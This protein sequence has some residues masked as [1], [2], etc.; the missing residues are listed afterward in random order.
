MQ[1]IYARRISVLISAFFILS[2]AVSSTSL[3]AADK[4]DEYYELMK[5]FV[6]TF[7]Q[8][9]RN[10]V[11]KVDRKE[12]MEAAIRGMVSKLDQYSNY[13]SP[14][15]LSQFTQE[16]EQEFGGI[17]I[18]VQ[19]DRATRR[20]LVMTPL[21]GTP[22]YNAG[23]RAG[24]LIMD[25]EGKSTE[26]ITLRQAVRLLKGK[27]GD[28]VNI[29]IKHDDS[30]AIEKIEIVRAV[31]KVATVLGDS[32]NAD[33]SWNFMVDP[34]NKIGFIRLTHF[35]R[36]SNAELRAAIDQLR[37]QDMKGLIIDLRFNPGGL[38]SQAVSIADMFIESGKIVSTEGNNSPVR[39]FSAHKAGTYTDFP[40]AILVNRYSASASEIVGACLQDHK[41]AVI[42]G[43]RSWGKG[44]VQNV[45]ELG[46]GN[47]ALKL[48]TASYHRPS[49]KNIH[50]FPGA[51]ESDEWGV[52]PDE[53]YQVRFSGDEM[54]KYLDYRRKRDVLKDEG[55]PESDYEDRQFAKAREYLLEKL[56]KKDAAA[57]KGKKTES[58]KPDKKKDKKKENSKD[59]KA[60]KKAKGAAKL[61]SIILIPRS[62]T[63]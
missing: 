18:Q 13:I 3:R 44:S 16:V 50:K 35:S 32:Y 52:R 58:P 60:E 9:E 59:K 36:R 19:I 20:L 42:V 55:P 62:Q 47:S 49:G 40:I 37:K 48:T 38:L 25:I 6:D 53:G 5:T 33:D 2:L 12:L 56:A 34:E 22:A 31:I 11:K 29:G 14:D 24:D 26:G 57:K 23:V 17:G 41:R 21:P 8:I 7:E 28:A 10:Y 30:E 27:P 15:D 51:K 45:I 63:V 39:V 4:E 46:G 43:E 54:R 1:R 61:P